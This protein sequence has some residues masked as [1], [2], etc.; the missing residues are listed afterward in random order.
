MTRESFRQNP[1]GNSVIL[2]FSGQKP[3]TRIIER[4][5][6]SYLRFSRAQDVISHLSQH[7]RKFLVEVQENEYQISPEL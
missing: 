2:I 7:L 1:P 5:L 4:I 6:H 3:C